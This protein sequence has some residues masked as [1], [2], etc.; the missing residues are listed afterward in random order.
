MNYC[1]N[2]QIIFLKNLVINISFV[3][4]IVIRFNHYYSI[5]LNFNKFHMNF[6]KIHLNHFIIIKNYNLYFTV[7]VNLK[8]IL[9]YHNQ[10]Y[11]NLNILGYSFLFSSHTLLTLYL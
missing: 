6:G 7:L 5:D 11:F 8:N 10:T 2:N 3:M 9:K 4:Y 1:F